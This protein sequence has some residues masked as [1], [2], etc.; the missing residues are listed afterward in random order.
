MLFYIYMLI[1]FLF[2]NSSIIFYEYFFFFYLLIV[3]FI[4]DI[5]KYGWLD[6]LNFFICFF[7][8]DW[9]FFNFVI[10]VVFCCSIVWCLNIVFFK[11][12]FFW[13]FFF[14]VFWICFICFFILFIFY[15]INKFFV[16]MEKIKLVNIL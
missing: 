11:L 4:S 7:S 16:I 1:F 12:M 3:C 14:K 10:L 13:Y 9:M 2:I 8:F 6:A 15:I 5:I